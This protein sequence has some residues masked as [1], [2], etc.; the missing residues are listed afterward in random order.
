MAAAAQTAKEEQEE[1][2]MP[3]SKIV[4]PSD[5]VKASR[6]C[7]ICKEGFQSEFSE[8]DEEWLWVDA[9]ELDG[10]VSALSLARVFSLRRNGYTD[11]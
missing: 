6:P 5:P 2:P 10:I 1:A 11:G 8:E 3:V 7:P 4:R 9:I